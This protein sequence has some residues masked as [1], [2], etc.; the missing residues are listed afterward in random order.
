MEYNIYCDESCHLPNDN[1]TVMIIGGISCPKNKVYFINNEI[2]NVKKKY[3]IYEFVEIKWTKVS[4]SKLEMYKELVDVFFKY[5]FLKFRCV[6][7]T[8]KDK[9]EPEKYNLSYNDWYYRMYYLMLKEMVDVGNCFNV[10][11]DIKDTN[12]QT[13]IKRLKDVL[14]RTLYDFTDS[15]VHLIQEVRSDQ[16]QIL[17]MADLIIGAIS[18]SARNL[19]KSSSKKELVRYISEK[20]HRPLNYT[21]PKSEIK[22]NIFKWEPRK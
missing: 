20:S 3:G 13:K 14:N 19:N 2:R 6:I 18:Y 22:F 10:F 9:L 1:S 5:D 4:T 21:T 8:N 15:T 11:I 7:A 16:V 17:Q 12:G